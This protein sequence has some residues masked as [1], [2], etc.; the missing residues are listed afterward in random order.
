MYKL[1]YFCSCGSFETSCCGSLFG[2]SLFSFSSLFSVFSL[3][4]LGVVSSFVSWEGVGGG[5]AGWSGCGWVGV[6]ARG[7]VEGCEE[8]CGRRVGGVSFFLLK[9]PPIDNLRSFAEG[10]TPICSLIIRSENENKE[11]EEEEGRGK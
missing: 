11:K 3:F 8:G 2:C 5:G 6:G 4:S 1:V 10:S 9:S 7:C